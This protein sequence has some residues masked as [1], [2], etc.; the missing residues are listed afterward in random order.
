MSVDDAKKIL[1]LEDGGDLKKAYNSA[2]KKAHPDLGGSDDEMKK[3]NQAYDILKSTNYDPS[4]RADFEKRYKQHREEAEERRKRQVIRVTEI[5][6]N[7]EAQF[8]SS[9]NTWKKHFEPFFPELD[10]PEFK[11]NI[12]DDKWMPARSELFINWPTD[13]GKTD[14]R[15]KVNVA[16]DQGNG[17]SDNT[18][19]PDYK[20]YYET[21]LYHNRKD[22]KM[23]QR[24]W[25]KYS[26][27]SSVLDPEKVFPSA[28]LKRVI[29]KKV[30]NKMT[31]KA[32]MKAIQSELKKYNPDFRFRG[33]KVVFD[34]KRDDGA[35]FEMSRMVFNRIPFWSIY[36]RIG[37]YNKKDEL[38]RIKPMRPVPPQLSDSEYTNSFPETGDALDR[39][40]QF[41][42]DIIKG[43]KIPKDYFKDVKEAS[44]N[45]D[46]E[47]GRCENLI[48]RFN[49]LDEKLSKKVI[50]DLTDFL[51]KHLS[52]KVDDLVDLEHSKRD[53]L[54]LSDI[55]NRGA[56]TDP[57]YDELKR[58]SNEYGGNIFRIGD[59]GG[60]GITIHI[61]D[62]DRLSKVK[63]ESL[64]ETEIKYNDQGKV[65]KNNAGG[66]NG[67][68]LAL[69]D[70]NSKKLGKIKVAI[71]P[72]TK[73]FGYKKIE[74]IKVGTQITIVFKETS[75]GPEALE[76]YDAK[77]QIA[78]QMGK[79]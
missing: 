6:N 30:T 45:E 77:S 58:L 7:I 60:L 59:N 51:N 9:L 4:S 23:A 67:I 26:T 69:V 11:V 57:R 21:S 31:K 5:I 3:V 79:L 64:E 18:S 43:K 35:V 33:D 63:D 19:E 66:P 61:L 46:L 74:D 32:F 17:L 65:S 28:K 13:D 41:F 42:N 2:S 75:R 53:Y 44:K 52:F 20:V 55:I 73:L 27:S 22:N 15:L 72:N 37:E 49:N 29:K 54:A 50:A 62:K 56:S 39:V 8:K 40:K 47:M 1:G 25:G 12:T 34:F 24:D 14:I 38:V 36:T 78:K 16:P 68:D 70:V 10:K 48:E 76:V 71:T